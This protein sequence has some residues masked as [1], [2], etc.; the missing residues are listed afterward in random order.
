MPPT[1][2]ASS[3]RTGSTS[4]DQ[5]ECEN[6]GI[7][8]ARSGRSRWPQITGAAFVMQSSLRDG[9]TRRDPRPETTARAPAYTGRRSGGVPPFLVSN[10]IATP[11]RSGRQL[12]I[13]RHGTEATISWDSTSAPIGPGE[14]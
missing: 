14:L 8:R 3:G 4:R 13:D 1:S 5:P 7:I 10:L 9:S 2:T 12:A 6:I 11:R